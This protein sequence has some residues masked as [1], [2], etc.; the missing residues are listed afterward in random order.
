MKIFILFCSIF[1]TLKGESLPRYWLFE[2]NF[3]KLGKKE[4]Y[5]EERKKT[6][7]GV[8]VLAA[9]DL[10]N[11]QSV[12]LMPLKKGL[13]SLKEYLPFREQTSFLLG[14]SLHFQVFSLQELLEECCFRPEDVFLESR[15]YFLYFLYEV[16]MGQEKVFEEQLKASILRQIVAQKEKKQEDVQVWRTWKVL[17]GSD[18][19]KYLI[20][21][22]F[23]TKE[24][25]KEGKEVVE[26]MSIRDIL[27][28]KKSGWMKRQDNLTNLKENS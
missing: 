3:F 8:D 1:F 20:C 17:L 7:E 22:S 15:P 16:E 14:T 9:L 11:P 21:L 4:L 6:L 12:L 26:E 24:A 27:R 28:G 10:D 2:E 18:V 25:L 23:P 5:E 19:P 13:L